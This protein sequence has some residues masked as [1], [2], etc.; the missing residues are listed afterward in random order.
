MPS[1]PGTRYQ[2]WCFTLNNYTNDDIIHI[3]SLYGDSANHI[4]YLVIGREVGDNDTPHLQGF[5]S[6]SRRYTLAAVK[7]LISERAHFEGANGTSAQAATYCKKDGTFTEFGEVPVSG[8]TNYLEDFFKWSDAFR[9]DNGRTP[10]ARDVALEHPT[11]L[12]RHRNILDVLTHRAPPPQLVANPEPRPWQMELEEHLT[13]DSPDDRTVEFFVDEDGGKGK[14]WFQRHMLTKYP[15][16][17]QLLAPAK[18]DDMAHTIDIQKSIFLVNVP[19]TQMEFLQYSLLEQLKDRTVFSPKYSS[20]MKILTQTP[21]VVVFSN[22]FPDMNK[23]SA[24]RYIVQEL[25]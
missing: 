6:F 16:K 19:K 12:V 22:E 1:A 10:T 23:M 7:A 8:K 20:M 2:R 11:V 5:V 3:E 14:S 13:D 9:E 15:D 4:Q 18:R 17:V 24:D 21:H 25:E